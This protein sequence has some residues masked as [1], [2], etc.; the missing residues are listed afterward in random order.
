MFPGLIGLSVGTLL[1]AA[2]FVLL[3][4]TGE[5]LGM[6]LVVSAMVL[7][8]ILVGFVID[9]L[10]HARMH[11]YSPDI[12]ERNEF[13]LPKLEHRPLQNTDSRLYSIDSLQQTEGDHKNDDIREDIQTT[14]TTQP[15][16]NTGLVWQ[17]L[18]GDLVHNFLDGVVIGIS[19]LD[20]SSTGWTVTL[21]V[22]L[23]EL[24]QEMG[25]FVLLLHGGWSKWRALGANVC[26]SVAT[27][28]GAVIVVAAGGQHTDIIDYGLPLTAGIFIYLALSTLVPQIQHSPSK[29]RK[30]QSYVFTVIGAGLM[31]LL[32]L[33]PA[34]HS[35][36]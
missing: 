12:H 26:V 17:S 22:L 23:H 15:R 8:G 20:S 29:A 31:G 33:Y 6:D 36:E 21:S 13:E 34:E 28:V 1:G 16:A 3:P 25:D 18:I 4:E 7:T 32:L 30:R 2:F 14:A 9:S 19:F 27:F 5:L 35:E 11:V 10:V 24:P